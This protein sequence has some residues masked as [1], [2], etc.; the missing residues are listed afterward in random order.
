MT[1]EGQ[2]STRPA[3]ALPHTES[4]RLRACW[5]AARPPAC[6]EAATRLPPAALPAAPAA[7][8]LAQALPLLPVLAVQGQQQ[9]TALPLRSPPPPPPCCRPRPH[10]CCPPP[11]PLSLCSP[12]P[13][14]LHPQLCLLPPL[15]RPQGLLGQLLGHPCCRRRCQLPQ[16]QTRPQAA[17]GRRPAWAGSHPPA[18]TR[19]TARCRQHPR[20]CSGSLHPA[21]EIMSWPPRCKRDQQAPMAHVLQ[22]QCQVI[23]GVDNAMAP[24]RRAT[25]LTPAC[26]PEED[27]QGDGGLPR[28][29]RHRRQLHGLQYAAVPAQVLQY[30]AAVQVLLCPWRH[31]HHPQAAAPADECRL[32]QAGSSRLSA[33]SC[34]SM[35]PS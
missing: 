1:R 27:A 13:A 14:L 29:S 25:V 5:H 31:L 26:R 35:C 30:H 12:T 18:G 33:P 7:P 22:Q 34:P 17:A 11:A 6:P 8:C 4:S 9:A 3:H 23:C 21:T 32:L 24:H 19:Q 16:P 10:R 15:Q 28:P 20:S 2:C